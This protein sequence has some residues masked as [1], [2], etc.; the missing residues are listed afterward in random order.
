MA[1]QGLLNAAPCTF[2]TEARRMVTELQTGEIL[3]GRFE[4]AERIGHRGMGWV[5]KATDLTTG[6]PVAV[7]SFFEL[8]SDPALISLF[9][10]EIE[11]GR[12]LDHP[13]ILK[14][15]IVDN[16]SRLYLATELLDGET[17]WDRL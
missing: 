10:H 15:L 17:L 2:L 8:E 4:I 9:R 11:I 7:N 5:F 1:R 16:P 13:G 3:D 6:C 12:S 14:I